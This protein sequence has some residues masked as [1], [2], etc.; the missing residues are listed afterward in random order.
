MRRSE[1]RCTLPSLHALWTPNK[2]GR[3]AR[4]PPWPHSASGSAR[5]RAALPVA[6]THTR[7]VQT[8]AGVPAARPA[9]RWPR[10]R[11]RR[12]ARPRSRQPS[13]ARPL[14]PPNRPPPACARKALALWTAQTDAAWHRTRASSS[15]THSRHTGVAGGPGAGTA[16]MRQG[17]AGALSSVVFFGSLWC[18][19]RSG[20][21]APALAAWLR[22]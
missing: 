19:P 10:A 5:A 15:L 8:G 11:P 21:R 17:C 7:P 22:G 3:A 16:H 2:I 12:R 14:P 20:R 18:W 4:P 9:W 13:P 1:A 6:R